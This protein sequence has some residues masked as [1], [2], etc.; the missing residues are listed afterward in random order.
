[1]IHLTPLKGLARIPG[2]AGTGQLKEDDDDMISVT[3]EIAPQRKPG[4]EVRATGLTASMD[5]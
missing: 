1:M 3:E 5:Q 4:L 2:N